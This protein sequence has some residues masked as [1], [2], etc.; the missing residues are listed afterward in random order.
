MWLTEHLTVD[1]NVKFE[2]NPTSWFTGSQLKVL[3]EPE[4][5]RPSPFMP[6]NL[7]DEKFEQQCP[8]NQCFDLPSHSILGLCLFQEWYSQFSTQCMLLFVSCPWKQKRSKDELQQGQRSSTV[9][10]LSS[11]IKNTSLCSAGIQQP[12][13]CLLKVSRL[14]DGSYNITW[15]TPLQ[16]HPWSN[17]Q[18]KM[19][20]TTVVCFTITM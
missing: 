20:R 9:L 4:R 14:S 2:L 16:S 13:I 6:L 17:S 1:Q 5:P 19:E 8:E 15:S 7:I 3:V 12:C 11:Q 18:G 10:K